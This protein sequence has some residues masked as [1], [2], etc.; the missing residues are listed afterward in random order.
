M[1]Q[2]HSGLTR[3]YLPTFNL[4]EEIPKLGDIIEKTPIGTL[5]IN[6]VALNHSG[7]NWKIF[8]HKLNPN[9][10]E[11]FIFAFALIAKDSNPCYSGIWQF[12]SNARKLEKAL[13][14]N[15]IKLTKCEYDLIQRCK[16]FSKWSDYRVLREKEM[17]TVLMTLRQQ[18]LGQYF[19]QIG[20]G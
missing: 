20:T 12:E 15:N 9:N 11:S 14:K 3:T 17:S 19:R 4:Q 16:N 7:L 8:R 13:I 2:K 5:F 10:Y 18:Y 6:H 1:T